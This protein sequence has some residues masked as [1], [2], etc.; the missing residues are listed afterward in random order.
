M[1]GNIDKMNTILW[2]LSSKCNFGCKYCYL[3]FEKENN[4]INNKNTENN[5]DV[6]DK[7]VINFIKKLEE[8]KIKRV[9]IAGAEPLSNPEKTFDIIKKIKGF[10][11]QVVLCTNGYLINKFYKEI[12]ATGV[13]AVSISLDSYKKEY[14][15][16][17]N[18]VNCE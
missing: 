8:Y 14:N 11:I 5:A 17:F 10:N 3:K 18:S 9:F 15:K 7:I 2:A 16:R 12:I 13:D 1:K 4:P 6:N